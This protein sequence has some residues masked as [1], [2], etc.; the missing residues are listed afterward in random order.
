MTDET[1][2]PGG[3]RRGGTRIAVA[4]AALAL[5]LGVLGA[6]A[7]GAFADGGDSSGSGAS[8]AATTFVQSGSTTP[9]QDA[10]DRGDCPEGAPQQ[11]GGGE[12]SSTTP[13]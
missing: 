12:G 13:S 2:R 10:P 4:A 1:D 6:A 5:G 3:R 7:A 11:E 8:G 9:Q